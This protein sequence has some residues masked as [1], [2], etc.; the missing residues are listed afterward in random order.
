[1]SVPRG[2][3]PTFTLTLPALSGVDLTNAT[4]VYATFSTSK[5][6]GKVITKSGEDLDVQ[7]LSVGVFLSQS[8]TLSFSV[9]DIYIQLNWLSPDGK[10]YATDIATYKISEQLLQKVIE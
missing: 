1:M 7:P 3:T 6:G 9:G 4:S 8:E 2:T 10:R 5:S